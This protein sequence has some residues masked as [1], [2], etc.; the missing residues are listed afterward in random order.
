M[1][2]H[3]P[4]TAAAPFAIFLAEVA[5]SI[6]FSWTQALLVYGPLGLWVAWFV[7]RDRLDREERKQ[8]RIDQERRHQ[9]NLAA[10]RAVENAFRTNTNSI[11]VGM[12]AT[13]HM[14]G[15]FTDLLE[16]IKADNATNG[17]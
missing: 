1:I 2:L 10:Q 11:I 15:A 8:E 17:K 7:I 5:S 3:H 14:D 6:P 13:K 12:A 4:I 9:E 16:R